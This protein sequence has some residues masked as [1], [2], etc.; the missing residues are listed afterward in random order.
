MKYHYSK[1]SLENINSCCDPLIT[2][3]KHAIKY[4]DIICEEGYRGEKEQTVYYKA[5]TSKV[6]YPNSK[7]NKT[8]SEAIHLAPYDKIKRGIDWEDRELLVKFGFFIVGLA[9]S[10]GI[11][12]RWGGDW[13]MDGDRSDQNFDDLVHFEFVRYL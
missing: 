2:V 10:L 5:R 3:A 4:W 11:K 6:Q 9:Y 1:R 8:P 12:I 7:H 13:D